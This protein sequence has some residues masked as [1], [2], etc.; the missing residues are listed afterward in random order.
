[1]YE[2]ATFKG[3]YERAT[4]KGLYERA[5]C[6]KRRNNFNVV[7]R[8]DTIPFVTP[9]FRIELICLKYSLYCTNCTKLNVFNVWSTKGARKIKQEHSYHEKCTGGKFFIFRFAYIYSLY[10]NCI[11]FLNNIMEIFVNTSLYVCWYIL[12]VFCILTL[13]L[14]MYGHGVVL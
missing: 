4:C 5:T 12:K 11:R 6:I 8:R 13:T 7:S 14:R 2:R 1:M 10:T 9:R 3:L